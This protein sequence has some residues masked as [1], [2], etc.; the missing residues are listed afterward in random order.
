[1]K[2]RAAA[3]QGQGGFTLIELL[4]VVAIIGILAAIAIPQYQNYIARSNASAAYSEASSFKTPV[5]AELFDGN[6]PSSTVTTP[7]TV[8]IS[9]DGTGAGTIVSTRNG[10]SVTLTRTTGGAWSCANGFTGVTL[11]NC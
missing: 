10:S 2:K 4:I 3:K 1:M 8:T 7:A 9:V 6:D 5:E 11:A